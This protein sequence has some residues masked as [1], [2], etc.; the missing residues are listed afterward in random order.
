MISFSFRK[1]SL[2][3]SLSSS[4]STINFLPL[5]IDMLLVVQTAI[6][7]RQAVDIENLKA[8][9]DSLE[10]GNKRKIERLLKTNADE[11]DAL[12]ESNCKIVEKLKNDSKVLNCKN[13]LKLKVLLHQIADYESQVNSFNNEKAVIVK[14]VEACEKEIA[15]FQFEIE[16]KDDAISEQNSEIE[17]FK[18]S[19]EAEAKKHAD[20]YKNLSAMLAVK[21]RELKE[22]TQRNELIQIA[23]ANREIA[24]KEKLL[25][26][27]DRI[28]VF[29]D[30]VLRKEMENEEL[31]QA[32]ESMQRKLDDVKC[33]NSVLKKINNV[34][35]AMIK[36][37]ES[38]NQSLENFKARFKQVKT[39]N[40]KNLLRPF[41]N[42]ML[43]GV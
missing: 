12:K 4:A 23:S 21:S 28:N 15:R 10:A 26:L 34:H 17:G 1:Q 6:I 36:G 2:S 33:E 30:S 11:I 18:E 22:M 7:L 5:I 31:K 39:V 13:K 32:V 24:L 14:S 35:E 16:L 40:V 9:I 27:Q 37:L 41:L 43:I 8:R 29:C 42:I 3:Y 25:N 19:L 20:C 38:E